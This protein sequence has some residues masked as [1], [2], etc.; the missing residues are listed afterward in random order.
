MK[1]LH[2]QSLV[3]TQLHNSLSWLPRGRSDVDEQPGKL[4]KKKISSV[5]KTTHVK[6]ANKSSRDYMEIEVVLHISI[7]YL[8]DY[9]LDNLL[10]VC[11]YIHTHLCIKPSNKILQMHNDSNVLAI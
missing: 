6:H 1:W 2:Q 3:K 9:Y 11:V 4:N 10:C 7:N 8:E 5:L